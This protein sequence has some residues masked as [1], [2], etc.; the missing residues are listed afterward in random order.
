MSFDENRFSGTVDL[1][2]LPESMKHL[3]VSKNA[4]SVLKLGRTGAARY[5]AKKTRAPA[6]GMYQ[7]EA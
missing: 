4:L 2:N 3:D 1:G 7:A 5:D 6:L